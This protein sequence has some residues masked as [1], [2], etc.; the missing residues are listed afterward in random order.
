MAA[1][2]GPSPVRDLPTGLPP[3]PIS[4][5]GKERPLPPI[6]S[7]AHPSYTSRTSPPSSSSPS[8][9]SSTAAGKRRAVSA[10]LVSAYDALERMLTDPRILARLLSALPWSAFHALISTALAHSCYSDIYNMRKHKLST[11]TLFV[12][13]IQRTECNDWALSCL[14]RRLLVSFTARHCRQP[15]R[16]WPASAGKSSRVA[17]PGFAH[18]PGGLY[19]TLLYHQPEMEIYVRRQEFVISFQAS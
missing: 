17:R 4:P 1:V 11:L 8:A 3:S 5:K 18:G 2:D 15:C 14:S 16:P 19:I 12:L 9:V 7:T 6:P 10:P 13:S